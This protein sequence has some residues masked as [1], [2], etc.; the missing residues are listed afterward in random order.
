MHSYLEYRIYLS[1]SSKAWNEMRERPCI[2]L[3]AHLVFV[4][5]LFECVN[6]YSTVSKLS[7]DIQLFDHTI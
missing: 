4:L 1:V 6:V 3:V 2:A 5:Y 7:K